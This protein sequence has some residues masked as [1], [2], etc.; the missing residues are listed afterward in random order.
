MFLSIVTARLIKECMCNCVSVHNEPASKHTLVWARG[1]AVS[2][3]DLPVTDG[4]GLRGEERLREADNISTS[5]CISE[6]V[7]VS[8]TYVLVRVLDL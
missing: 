2:P 8:C 5:L 6:S 7:C 1:P 4:N 3:P